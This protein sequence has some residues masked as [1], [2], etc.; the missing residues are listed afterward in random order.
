MT[1]LD[2]GKVYLCLKNVCCTTGSPSTVSFENVMPPSR[3]VRWDGQDLTLSCKAVGG[4][5]TPNVVLIIDG[6]TVASQTQ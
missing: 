3:L 1:K 6:Q 2:P 5:P 4:K